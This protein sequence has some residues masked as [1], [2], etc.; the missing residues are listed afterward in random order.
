MT[1]ELVILQRTKQHAEGD[2]Q[3]REAL[4]HLQLAASCYHNAGQHTK[5]ARMTREAA[6][7]RR[8]REKLKLVV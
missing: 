6:R 5:A 8:L 1:I 3:A 2:K 4:E 7:L